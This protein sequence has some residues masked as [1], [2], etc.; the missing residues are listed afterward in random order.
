MISN[1]HLFEIFR[2]SALPAVIIS[3][4]TPHFPIVAA[5]DAWRWMFYGP[6]STHDPAGES[7]LVSVRDQALGEVLEVVVATKSARDHKFAWSGF[8]PKN[9]WASSI[10][11]FDANGEVEYI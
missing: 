6:D 11:L 9:L 8:G 5:N 4:V 3:P 1:A 2:V 10:P 7:V